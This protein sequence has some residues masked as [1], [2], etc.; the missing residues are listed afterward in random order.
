MYIVSLKTLVTLK[1]R[2]LLYGAVK[3]AGYVLWQLE[4]QASNVTA[5][6]QSDHHLH[7]YTFAVFL[8]LI[9]RII[10]HALL[11]YCP[12]LNN[13]AAAATLAYCWLVLISLHASASCP[14]MQQSTGF[15][16]RL[17]AGHMSGLM[18]SGVSQRR[19][20]TVS[21]TRFAGA[22]SWWKTNTSPAMLRITGSG[23]CVSNTS[24]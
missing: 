16:S 14:Q 15:R 13:N 6:V 18:N 11:K 19:S 23:S 10:H 5:S 20:S 21:R 1:R 4:G 24:R 12:C 2:V 17:L 22:L 9:N 7:G 3:R 8:P